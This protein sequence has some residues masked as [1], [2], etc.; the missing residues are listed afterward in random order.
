MPNMYRRASVNLSAMIM[1]HV[2]AVCLA[3]STF[4]FAM[5]VLMVLGRKE[6]ALVSGLIESVVI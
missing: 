5:L 2:A 3:E 1:H 4:A 6:N